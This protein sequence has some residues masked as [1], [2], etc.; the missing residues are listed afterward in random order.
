MSKCPVELT[1]FPTGLQFTTVSIW[2]T[3]SSATQDWL[4]IP[5]W[6]AILGITLAIIGQVGVRDAWHVLQL[7]FRPLIG[8][9]PWTC[10]SSTL[11]FS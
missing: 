10:R 11:P 9:C 1:P 5:L 3:T 8:L 4:K 2:F 6:H 7:R